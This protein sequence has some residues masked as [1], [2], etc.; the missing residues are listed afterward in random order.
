MVSLPD[1]VV[2]VLTADEMDPLRP[3][4]VEIAITV[5]GLFLLILLAFVVLMMMLRG[6]RNQLSRDS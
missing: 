6:R 1:R 5:G 2:G 3:S 4:W